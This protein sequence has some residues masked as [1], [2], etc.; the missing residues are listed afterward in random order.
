MLPEQRRAA[1]LKLHS[2][3]SE[4]ECLYLM[5]HSQVWLALLFITDPKRRLLALR[6]YLGKEEKEGPKSL[7]DHW[8]WSKQR[9]AEYE[10][11]AEE[12]EASRAI[13]RVKANF[14][15]QQDMKKAAFHLSGSPKTRDMPYQ[16][17]EWNKGKAIA[18]PAAA[19]YEQAVQ[20]IRKPRY[21]DPP[22]EE[23][24]AAF[25]AFLRKISVSLVRATPGL[26][27]H[28]QSR[29]V[30]FIAANKS[31]KLEASSS[32]IGLWKSTGCAA[33]LKRAV[34][35]V[36]AA[37][38]RTVF[39]GP[40]TKARHGVEEPW[41]YNYNPVPA[42]EEAEAEAPVAAPPGAHPPSSKAGSLPHP[43]PV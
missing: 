42:R 23:S 19:V 12:K 43:Q 5:T 31:V 13:A 7:D 1:E 11:S 27:R 15:A 2:Y 20:E 37:A 6:G 41:H 17:K 29:A 38:K 36:N 8:T 39:D 30:D 40:L 24:L 14:E 32:L 18:G 9:I 34:D 28:G 25:G 4:A 10:G 3:A 33:A 35:A 21:K 16:M 26:S 22:D